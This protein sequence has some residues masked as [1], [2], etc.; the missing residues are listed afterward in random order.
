[1]FSE[2]DTACLRCHHARTRLCIFC[3]GY[4]YLHTIATVEATGAGT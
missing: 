1:M 2:Y 3:F 4:R